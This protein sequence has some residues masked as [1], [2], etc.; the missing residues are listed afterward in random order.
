MS[1]ERRGV[2]T[3]PT[4]MKR[5]RNLSGDSGV[6]AYDIGKDYVDV[7]FRN[8]D[9]YRYDRDTPGADHIENMKLLAL[10]GKGLS[11]Y[12]SRFVKGRYAR[13]IEHS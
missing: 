3:G 7:K 4:G 5:Y 12:I 8:G 11:S 13:K 6:V 9:V 10:A 1:G 2:F